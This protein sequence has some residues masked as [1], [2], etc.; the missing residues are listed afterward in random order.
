MGAV[1]DSITIIQNVLFL[2]PER[3]TVRP[4]RPPPPCTATP[5]NADEITVATNGVAANT[6][7]DPGTHTLHVLAEQRSPSAS[8]RRAQTDQSLPEASPNVVLERPRPRP[9]TRLGRQLANDEV[10]VQTLVKLREDGL[11]TLA[12]RA[13][14]DANKPEGGNGKYLQELLEAFSSD[15]WG[16]PADHRSDSSQSE[17][18]EEDVED[19][20]TLRA[21]IQAFEQQQVA[22]GGCGDAAE[23]HPG[24]D[25]SLVVAKKP[26]PR[27]RP[28]LQGQPAKSNPPVIA[29]KPKSFSRTAKPSSKVFWEDGGVAVASGSAETTETAAAESNSEAQPS[30]EPSA[31]CTSKPDPGS[32]LKPPQTSEKPSIT[33]KPQTVPA[34]LPSGAPVPA[35]RPSPPKLTA[36]V[37]AGSSPPTG[38]PRRPAVAPRASLGGEATQNTVTQTGEWRFNQVGSFK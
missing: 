8:T 17:S 3:R 20:A 10:K 6:H 21:R 36:S 2:F 30:A 13:N 35:P 32:E 24:N 27:P 19:M 18:E 33:P 5:L 12:A 7:P 9:R 22:E 31:S 26:E 16:F 11:A 23:M 25:E 38:R 28:R 15:D 14:N 34:P 1:T 29:P 37:S 4:P